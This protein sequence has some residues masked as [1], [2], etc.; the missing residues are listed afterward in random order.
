MPVSSFLIALS[1]RIILYFIKPDNE[2]SFA[3]WLGLNQ[4]SLL[5]PYISYSVSLL[6]A[7]NDIVVSKYTHGCL[8]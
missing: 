4:K 2:C 7:L 3:S 1:V 8:M 6:E 5:W